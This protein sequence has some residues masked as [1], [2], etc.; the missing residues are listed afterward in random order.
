M[1][2]IE[3]VKRNSGE[4]FGKKVPNEAKNE[5]NTESEKFSGESF[6]QKSA[7][8]LSWTELRN[9]TDMADISM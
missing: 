1:K 5:D 8:K 3:K 7:V 2:M 6:G 9:V 4:S